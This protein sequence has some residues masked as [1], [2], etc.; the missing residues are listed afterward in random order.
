MVCFILSKLIPK[1]STKLM[2]F[3]NGQFSLGMDKGYKN[4]DELSYNRFFKLRFFIL[5]KFS[6]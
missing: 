2:Q 4:A 6:D 1:T 5:G 3:S